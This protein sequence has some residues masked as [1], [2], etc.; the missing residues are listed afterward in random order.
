[1]IWSVDPWGYEAMQAKDPSLP[2]YIHMTPW[3]ANEL[4]TYAGQAFQIG[5]VRENP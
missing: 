3:F 2:F 1:M 4:G 5:I